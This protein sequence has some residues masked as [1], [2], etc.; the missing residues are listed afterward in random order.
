[1]R[2]PPA[3]AR[4]AA[5]VALV[6]GVASARVLVESRAALDE[7][8]AALARGAVDPGLRALRRAAHLY[9]PGNPA[10]AGAYD[11]L[12]RFARD[13]ETLGHQDHA[14][15]A[16][17]AVRSSALATRWLIV[18]HRERLDRANRRIARL[19]ALLPPPPE[20]RDTPVARREELHY[21]LLLEDR[22]PEPAWVLV[23][24]VSLALW[25]GGA[26]YAARR[27][28]DDDDRPRARPLAAAGASIAVGLIL[29]VLALVRA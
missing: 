29:F 24:G 5:A 8:R 7:G 22:A 25:L 28:W 15:V 3:V 1:V 20:E 6:L 27:G 9:L 11:A 2:P 19:M 10:N 16:W 4:Y 18:P 14:L 12:E 17:R 26:Y 13:Q 23:L 21:A